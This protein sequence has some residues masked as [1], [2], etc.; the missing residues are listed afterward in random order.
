MKTEKSSVPL[1]PWTASERY[2]D[3]LDS[4]KKSSEYY[5]N[6]Q[7]RRVKKEE[8]DEFEEDE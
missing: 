8:P 1:K 6:F 2:L 5:Q 4:L 3:W 7:K